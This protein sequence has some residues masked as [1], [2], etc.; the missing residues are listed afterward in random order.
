MSDFASRR[1]TMVDTQ[2]RPQDV[3]K[4]PIIAAM[5][6][7]PRERFVPEAAR[8]AA[9]VGQNLP[10][11]PGR[12]VLEPRSLAKLLD[13]LDVTPGESALVVAAGPGYSAAVLAEMGA[14]VTALESDAGM[15]AAA[16][17]NLGDK[18]KV[19]E[20]ALADGAKGSFDLILIEGAVETLP[21]ALAGQLAEGGRIGA[22]FMEGPLGIARIGLKSEGK[23]G[24]RQV[25]NATAP[26]LPGFSA[27]RGFVL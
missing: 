9:Y 14:A 17:A 4:F 24:W 20:G 12:V 5:L 1:V 26:V 27:R 19:V 15:A 11:A 13:A 16:R 3:T 22:I 21:E 2:V 10:L 18:A 8:E 25:F 23:I 6:S 7:V